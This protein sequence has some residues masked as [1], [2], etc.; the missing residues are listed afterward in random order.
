M[1]FD[2]VQAPGNTYWW[3]AMMHPVRVSGALAY[4]SPD[5][6]IAVFSSLFLC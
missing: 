6:Q 5:V 1:L 2:I 4:D 3:L